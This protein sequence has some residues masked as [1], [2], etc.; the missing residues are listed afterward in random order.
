[1]AA[2]GDGVIEDKNATKALNDVSTYGCHVL[3]I[4]GDENAPKFAYSI[5]IEKTSHQPDLIVTG[6][7][8]DVAHWII[9]EY[10]RRV[11]TGE[12]FIANVP[13][14]DF[15]DG[16]P[17]IFS[18][19]FKQHYRAHLGWG[20][21]FYGSDRFDVF[22]IIYPD[23]EGRWPWDDGVTDEYRWLMP[24]LCEMPVFH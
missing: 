21:W 23:K 6:L 16:F 20:L 10:N 15:I 3:K 5:G 2:K 19:F 9:N 13:Y 7:N 11:R 17:V 14:D 18:P 4:L 1:M 12:A 8:F 24:M 22:Q